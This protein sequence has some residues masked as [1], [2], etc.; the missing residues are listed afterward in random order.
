MRGIKYPSLL[1]GLLVYLL[2]FSQTVFSAEKLRI[3]VVAFEEKNNIGVE[4][5]G[6][7]IAEW[8]ATEINRTGKFETHERLL[9]TKVVEEKELLSSSLIDKAHVMEIGK[10]YG[11]EAI[12]TGSVM[13]FGSKISIT[14]RIINVKNGKVIKT[15]SVSTSSLDKVED[16][17][18]ILANMLSDISREQF[19]I[20]KDIKKKSNHRVEIGAA[21]GFA[22]T[23][24]DSIGFI[25]GVEMRYNAP[26][27]SSWITAIPIGSFR[28][29]ELGGVYN[30]KHY[31][32]VGFATG[33][34]FDEL[35]DYFETTYL[36]FGFII[37]PR[38]KMEMGL[39]I[40][41]ALTATIWTDTRI[42]GIDSDW[43]FPMNY[44]I[45]LS[46]KL[47][48]NIGLYSRYLGSYMGDFEDQ[49][50]DNYFYPGYFYPYVAGAFQFGLNYKFTIKE[51]L[52]EDK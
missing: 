28:N 46:Y 14:G 40:G 9:L 24:E 32:G 42:D 12:I 25:V 47:N 6:R 51:H 8:I 17:V 35:F 33:K 10:L 50:P 45:Y 19:E 20:E 22:K 18:I 52:P 31:L 48:R 11:T 13:K 37:R 4:N 43:R 49:L 1:L 30:V 44:S 36:H 5:A 34:T 41:G 16:K 29:I 2:L 7:I 26:R 38:I 27:I 15:S 39:F 21:P 3:G 23:K